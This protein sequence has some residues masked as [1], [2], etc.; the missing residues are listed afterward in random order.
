MLNEFTR[1]A[2]D[3]Q[4]GKSK[5]SREEPPWAA[6]GADRPAAQQD[7]DL[8]RV[9]VFGLV[10]VRVHTYGRRRMGNG[11]SGSTWWS[12]RTEARGHPPCGAG[13]GRAHSRPCRRLARVTAFLRAAGRAGHRARRASSA[14]NA[15][16]RPLCRGAPQRSP[17]PAPILTRA[18][19]SWPKTASNGIL[20][21]GTRRRVFPADRGHVDFGRAGEY[22]TLA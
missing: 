7:R 22:N 2:R 5:G 1:I 21:T 15:A 8:W 9:G 11:G 4:P 16:S 3:Y 19:I 17:C 20:P 13:G 6:K 10:M 12:G 18:A 14:A